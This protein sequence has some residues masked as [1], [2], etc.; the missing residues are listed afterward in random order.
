MLST[1]GGT[2]GIFLG[3]AIPYAVTHFFGIET[4][5]TFW[6]VFL[7]FGISVLIG[8]VF[9]VYPARRAARMNPIEALRH[10]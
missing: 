7:A 6:S 2:I 1:L 10:Q 9:G 5:V 3:A 4:A 8:I